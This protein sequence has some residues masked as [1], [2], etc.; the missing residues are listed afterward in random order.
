MTFICLLFI[1]TRIPQAFCSIQS[2]THLNE[3]ML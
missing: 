1:Y 3:E 2:I